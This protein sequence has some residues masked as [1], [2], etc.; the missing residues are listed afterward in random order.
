MYMYRAR[1]IFTSDI[2]GA[3]PPYGGLSAQP[4]NFPAPLYLAT[5][6]NVAVALAYDDRQSSHLA[7]TALARA[8]RAIGAVDF[9]DL[10]STDRSR[11]K[12]QAID[13]RA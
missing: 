11:L 6:E 1:F 2:C 3:W 10:L 4:N 13:Q 12:A 8:G 7:E 5:T 9:A